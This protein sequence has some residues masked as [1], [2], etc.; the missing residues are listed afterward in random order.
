MQVDCAC[1]S[2]LDFVCLTNKI[3]ILCLATVSYPLPSAAPS[4]HP[5]NSSQTGYSSLSNHT[6][7][8]QL[9][10]SLGSLLY[11][12]PLL[13]VWLNSSPPWKASLAS[14]PPS[15]LL[16]QGAFPTRSSPCDLPFPSTSTSNA[17]MWSSMQSLLCQLAFPT[18]ILAPCSE[19]KS[20]LG[21]NCA[22]ITQDLQWEIS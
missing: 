11:C 21:I 20:L 14:S 5:F 9:C 1:S 4:Q 18:Y 22:F 15:P 12:S 10:L 3:H 19:W 7:L 17:S 8:I 2:T 16:I 6:Q 13:D